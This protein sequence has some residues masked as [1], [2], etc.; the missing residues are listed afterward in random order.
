MSVT[1]IWDNNNRSEVTGVASSGIMG[2]Y[3]DHTEPEHKLHILTA[4]IIYRYKTGQ[5]KFPQSRYS[6]FSTKS[7][8]GNARSLSPLDN[9]YSPA[10]FGVV[11]RYTIPWCE[12]PNAGSNICGQ[13]IR[14]GVYI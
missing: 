12:N 5:N 11:Y 7:Q 8:P 9:R 6:F 3:I 13:K 2:T 10:L 14:G 4:D 1:K